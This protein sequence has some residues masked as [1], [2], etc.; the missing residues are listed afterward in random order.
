MLV[1]R[2]VQRRQVWRWLF[3]CILRNVCCEKFADVS[4]VLPAAVNVYQ[5]KYSNAPDECHIQFCV[6]PRVYFSFFYFL[7]QTTVKQVSQ[8]SFTSLQVPRY[9][10]HCNYSIYWRLP[11]AQLCRLVIALYKANVKDELRCTFWNSPATW[12]NLTCI[13]ELK[14]KQLSRYIQK[15]LQF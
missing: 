15:I 12:W 5:T 8:V 4:G 10:V 3:S 9:Y 11:L 2:Q 1:T 14:P 6:Y 13:C 7:Q